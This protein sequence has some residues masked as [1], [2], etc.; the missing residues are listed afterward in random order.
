LLTE[1]AQNKN[2]AGLILESPFN[3]MVAAA[4]NFYP[5]LPVSILLKDRYE[6]EKKNKE[7]EYSDYGFTW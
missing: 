6:N 2:Y 3:S 1:I 5:Y 7:C 4:K